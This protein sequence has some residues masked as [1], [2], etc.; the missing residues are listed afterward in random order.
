MDREARVLGGDSFTDV[1][2]PIDGDAIKAKRIPYLSSLGARDKLEY[3][4]IPI[5]SHL[6]RGEI[7]RD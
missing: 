2:R 3:V 5:C 1:R 7:S 6:L 4:P